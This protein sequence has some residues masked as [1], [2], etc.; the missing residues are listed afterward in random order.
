MGPPEIN[1]RF[2]GESIFMSILPVR[3][4]GHPEKALWEVKVVK[5][6]H[7]RSSEPEDAF[8]H[9]LIHLSIACTRHW[10]TV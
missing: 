2:T 8:L 6:G 5:S 1:G 4:L 9:S 3:T 7:P 10:A